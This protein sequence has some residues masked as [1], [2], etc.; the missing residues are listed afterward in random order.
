MQRNIITN[1]VSVILELQMNYRPIM[2]LISQSVFVLNELNKQVLIGTCYQLV[3][4]RL[5]TEVIC[6]RKISY[7]RNKNNKQKQLMNSIALPL[8]NLK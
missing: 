5:G 1:N 7:I 3:D 4:I 6:K 8:S 2:E